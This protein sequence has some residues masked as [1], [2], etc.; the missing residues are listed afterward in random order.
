MKL[1]TLLNILPNKLNA[2]VILL[3]LLLFTSCV[4]AKKYKAALAQVN[5]QEIQLKEA[6]ATIVVV[7]AKVEAL[8]EG[9][10]KCK[11]EKD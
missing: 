2:F 9:G 4:P 1:N 11:E 8:E 3:S 10:E 6:K 7:S 5:E